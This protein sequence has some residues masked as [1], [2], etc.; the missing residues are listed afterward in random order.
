MIKATEIHDIPELELGNEFQQMFI[1]S[2]NLTPG[3]RVADLNTFQL[4]LGKTYNVY[5]DMLIITQTVPPNEIDDKVNLNYCID[6][7]FHTSLALDNLIQVMIKAN[8][9]PDDILNYYE[10]LLT[11]INLKGFLFPENILLTCM[12]YARHNNIMAQIYNNPEINLRPSRLM[13]FPDNFYRG[14]KVIDPVFDR[15]LS[16]QLWEIIYNITRYVSDEGK[17]ELDK[18]KKLM[19]VWLQFFKLLDLLG[20]DFDSVG[21]IYSVF[22]YTQKQK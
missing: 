12:Q 11:E 4:V 1:L 22:N 3:E 18:H 16:L 6:F 15:L 21:R 7:N 19:E 8:I 5:H 9:T 17:E 13:D 2:K 10:A 14:G 20:H